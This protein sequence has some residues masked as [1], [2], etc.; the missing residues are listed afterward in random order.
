MDKVS[1]VETP[2]HM[3][4]A[5]A[6]APVKQI[7]AN[8]DLQEIMG[9]MIQ[10]DVQIYRRDKDIGEY[11]VRF[12]KDTV[13]SIRKQVMEMGFHNFASMHHSDKHDIEAVMTDNFIIDSRKGI[14]VPESFKNQKINEGSWMASFYIKDRKVYEEIRDGGYGMSIEGWFDHQL[15]EMK[16]QRMAA[17][18]EFA[19]NQKQK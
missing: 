12:S 15:V 11:F 3:K 13:K 8:D 6:F 14:K 5:Q 19:K 18:L 10:A 2:A 9:V 17:M 7:F 16:K 1:F 4:A